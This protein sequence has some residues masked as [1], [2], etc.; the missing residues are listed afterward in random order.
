MGKTIIQ[1]KTMDKTI[2]RLV[3]SVILTVCGIAAWAQSAMTSHVVSSGETL[4]SISRQYGVTVND[5]LG[6]NAGLTENIM[7]GQTIKIPST[8]ASPELKKQSP[9]KTTHIVQKKETIYGIAHQYGISEDELIA[10]NPIIQDGKK[11]KKG[12][13]LCI[14][15]SKE[16]KDAHQA[17][18]A[19]VMEKIEAQRQESLVKYYD[20]IKI[21][22]IAPFGLND[23]RR[24]TEAKKMTDFYKGFLMAVDTLKHKGIS[25]EIYTYEEPATDNSAA[26][27]LAQPMLKHMN[28]IVGPF[29][30]GNAAQVARFAAENDIVMVTP[31]S[32]KSYDLSAYR[33]VYEFS[34]PQNMVYDNVY[35]KFAQKYS[36]NNIV[37]VMMDDSKNNTVFVSRFKEKLQQKGVKFKS[38]AVGDE[39]F[40]EMFTSERNNI[41]IPSSGSETAFKALTNKLK[42]ISKDTEGMTIRLFGYPEWQ[43][44]NKQRELMKKYGATFYTTFFSN[45]AS[46]NVQRFNRN[47]LHWFQAPQI[48]SFPKYGELG[49]DIG[50]FFINAMKRL[51]SKMLTTQPERYE[52]IQST[53]YF[54][55]NSDKSAAMNNSVMFV[56]YNSDDTFTVER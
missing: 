32:T 51:G 29:K 1:S 46:T 3:M 40:A 39:K 6:A 26:S 5:I 16:E 47:F 36:N 45:P 12:A 14:P 50:Y 24:S 17:A 27:I 20:V 22:V 13:E 7:A 25:C 21:A 54:T 38:V 37:F 15:Y 55:R 11:L 33:N 44:Y 4:Y 19:V 18:Q 48:V 34:S 28:L 2:K 35:A 31:T 43:T 56:R 9:C 8:S 23:N 42:A 49:Y 53:L 30:Q 10:A 41:L 52:G